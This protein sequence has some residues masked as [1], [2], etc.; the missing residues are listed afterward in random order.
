MPVFPGAVANDPVLP[1]GL[2]TIGVDDINGMLWLYKHIH[3]GLP[4]EDCFFPDY[5]LEE[6]PHGCRPKYPLIFEIKQ[7]DEYWALKV[8]EDDRNI[9]INAQDQDGLTALHPR[10]ER[11]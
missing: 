11:F 3:E 7:G 2:E 9:E 6:A 10:V 1:D 4:L 8:I 5:E